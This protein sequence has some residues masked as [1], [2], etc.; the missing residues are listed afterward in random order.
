MKDTQSK[1]AFSEALERVMEK[2]PITKI[3][4]TDLVEESGLSRQTFY[5]HFRDIYDLIDWA[6]QEKTHLAF[7]LIDVDG[8]MAHVW[9][10]CL[11]LM[12]RSKNFYQQVITMA[13]HN[14]FYNGYYLRCQD[15]LLRMVGG[16]EHCDSTMLFTIRFIA[17]GITQMTTEWIAGGMVQPPEELAALFV[18]S[19]PVKYLQAYKSQKSRG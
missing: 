9:A 19:M 6:H 8:D 16:Q 13:G 11:R 14:S 2:K 15:N 1:Q 3:R 7:E 17:A 4:V 10:V 5:R 12:A 18:E